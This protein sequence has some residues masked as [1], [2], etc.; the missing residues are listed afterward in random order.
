MRNNLSGY[1]RYRGK[2]GISTTN[3]L[4]LV[5]AL[6]FAIADAGFGYKYFCKVRDSLNEHVTVETGSAVT[7]DLFVTEKIPAS[8]FI[9]DVSLIDTSVPGSYGIK[10]KTFGVVRDAVLDIVDTTAP[11]ASSV[12]QQIF[13]I[14]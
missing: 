10:I 3:T 13:H 14:A 12:P 7:Y 1:A 4:L 5:V 2:R 9:T 8:G 6:L 11:S